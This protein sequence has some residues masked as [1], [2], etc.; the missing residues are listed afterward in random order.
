MTSTTSERVFSRLSLYISCS[1]VHRWLRTSTGDR[2][3]F[4]LLCL[5]LGSRARLPSRGPP[6]GLRDRTPAQP[7]GALRC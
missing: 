1:L 5:E 2:K 4:L 6:W 3:R 7:P